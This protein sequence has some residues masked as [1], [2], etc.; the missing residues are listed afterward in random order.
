MTTE[1]AKA[2]LLEQLPVSGE[3]GYEAFWNSLQTSAEGREAITHFHQLRRAGDIS[4]RIDREAGD[5]VIS[6]P[7]AVEA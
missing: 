2:L 7:A 4:V 6:R 5:L 3:V 1:Q